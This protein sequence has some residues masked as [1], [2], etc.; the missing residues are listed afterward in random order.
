M[1]FAY[2]EKL[3]S[4]GRSSPTQSCGKSKSAVAVTLPLS[5]DTAHKP[6]K[7]GLST[8]NDAEVRSRGVGFPFAR[9][10]ELYVRVPGLK[11]QLVNGYGRRSTIGEA[12][13]SSVC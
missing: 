10:Y 7:G 12:P 3:N 8:M 6:P 1:P 11:S 9:E 4:K 5:D 13:Q 2:E